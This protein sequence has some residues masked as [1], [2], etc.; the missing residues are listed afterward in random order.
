MAYSGTGNEKAVLASDLNRGHIGHTIS[1]EPDEFTVV[2][3]RISAIARKEGGV[4]IA[5]DGVV[6]TGGFQANYSLPP[7]Q[8]V[9]VQPDMLTNTESTIKD[10]FGKVQDNLRGHKGDTSSEQ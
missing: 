8:N 5:L 1:F 7:T 9:Y 2:F 3:G 6:G 4:T 10:L